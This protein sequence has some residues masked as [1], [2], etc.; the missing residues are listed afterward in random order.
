M[1]VDAT[2]LV[3][4]MDAYKDEVEGKRRDL[5]TR[6]FLGG[7]GCASEE[8]DLDHQ[9]PKGWER[10]LDITTGKT[11]FQRL[12]FNLPSREGCCSA[13]SEALPEDSELLDLKLAG[14]GTTSGNYPAVCTLQSVKSAL[15]RAGRVPGN[16]LLF[17][18]ESSAATA[19]PSSSTTTSSMKRR[20]AAA[21][22]AAAATEDDDGSSDTAGGMMAGACSRCLLYVIISKTSPLCPR[23]DSQVPVPFIP[24][25]T[26]FDLNSVSK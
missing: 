13:S 11:Y 19:S 7:G 25:R 17:D 14:G 20:A 4:I 3:R 18:A 1:A 5:F 10:S 12:D 2:S 6:D 16:D 15:R 22:A 23:C 26:K 9:I 8:L 21:A 24:K